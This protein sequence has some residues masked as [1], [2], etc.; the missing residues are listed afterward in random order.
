MSNGN[1]VLLV[2]QLE[3]M[4]EEWRNM[5]D[6]PMDLSGVAFGMSPAFALATNPDAVEIGAK[7]LTTIPE[8][9]IW[10]GGTALDVVLGGMKSIGNLFR[11]DLVNPIDEVGRET[12]M[13]NRGAY[14]TET[15]IGERV[16]GWMSVDDV[17]YTHIDALKNE[18][19]EQWEAENTELADIMTA[20]DRELFLEHWARTEGLAGGTMGY[21]YKVDGNENWQPMQ[22]I[23]STMWVG[24]SFADLALGGAGI[25]S[26]VRVLRY[27]GNTTFVAGATGIASDVMRDLLPEA[28]DATALLDGLTGDSGSDLLEDR[29]SIRY[30]Q[31]NINNAA[32]RTI[33]SEVV[34]YR[35]AMENGEP[36]EGE[37]PDY[38]DITGEMNPETAQRLGMLADQ[39]IPF[40]DAYA[41][42][43]YREQQVY[44]STLE[45]EEKFHELVARYVEDP[46]A[47][48]PTEQEMVVMQFWMAGSGFTDLIDGDVPLGLE[49]KFQTLEMLDN[50]FRENPEAYAMFNPEEDQV[51]ASEF[52][53]A[54][55]ERFVPFLNFGEAAELNY[56]ENTDFFL[57]PLDEIQADRASFD[58]RVEQE[59]EA[60]NEAIREAS[61]NMPLQNSFGYL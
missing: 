52:A 44:A 50:Y 22:N 30:L 1:D 54:T 41:D 17:E 31:R 6:I 37:S 55:M 53:R 40:R 4:R 11:G 12:S 39:L 61:Q 33:D 15:Q 24:G 48:D 59:R 7:Q 34:R 47:F 18:H 42:G 36:W 26:K 3:Q 46:M 13:G 23:H 9:L 51:L 14:W 49:G 25:L 27:A 58:L 21:L 45:L 28:G 56:E 35:E 32:E 57:R 29:R 38:L 16:A 8:G 2:S 43:N 5:P 60:M 20:E 10:F 19:W